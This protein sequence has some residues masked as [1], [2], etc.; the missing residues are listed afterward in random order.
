MGLAYAPGERIW[1]ELLKIG[2]GRGFTAFRRLLT[3]PL[4]PALSE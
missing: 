3:A 1:L 2:S 4:R